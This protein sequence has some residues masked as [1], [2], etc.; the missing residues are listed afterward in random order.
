MK[1]Y[2]SAFLCFISI[3]LITKAWQ[4]NDPFFFYQEKHGHAGFAYV[5]QWYLVNDAPKH[6]YD[7]TNGK[8]DINVKPLWNQNITGKGIVIGIVDDFIQGD[9][10]DLAPNYREDLSK[11]FYENLKISDI[12]KSSTIHYDYPYNRY[13]YA[14]RYAHGTAVA[15]IAAASGGNGI[16]ITGVAPHAGLAGL[17]SG[18]S[19]K[20]IDATWHLAGIDKTT[21]KY[22][23]EPSIHIKN[24]SYKNR[25][26]LSKAIGLTSK[27]NVIHV[28]AAGNKR[29]DNF[30]SLEKQGPSHSIMVSAMN[31]AGNYTGYSNYGANVFVTAPGGEGGGFTISSK[32]TNQ[33]LGIFRMPTTDLSWVSAGYNKGKPEIVRRL[34]PLELSRHD[35]S[36]PD[37]TAYFAGTSGVAPIVSGTLALAKEINPL[38]DHR[39][40]KHCLVK[41]S[42]IVDRDDKSYMG[43][44]M[45]NAAGIYFNNNYG[46]GLIDATALGD[47]VQETAYVTAD[48]ESIAFNMRNIRS[49]TALSQTFQFA[50][51]I[52]F[53][54]EQLSFGVD[55]F[56]QDQKSFDDL[57]IDIISPQG[58]RS[59][60][61]TPPPYC[62]LK[63]KVDIFYD[64]LPKSNKCFALYKSQPFT[65]NTF[66]GENAH[67][68]WT[69]SLQDATTGLE[70][71]SLEDFQATLFIGKRIPQLKEFQSLEES[72]D[73][74]ALTLL[75][76]N[77]NWFV[78]EKGKT[79]R[80]KD[81]ILI[82]KV[83][84][85]LMARLKKLTSKAIAST[86]KVVS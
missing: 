43:G 25:N 72:A 79:L 45:K 65:T 28:V 70:S 10:P 40:A 1:N 67:G 83:P 24:H 76:H 32:V 11:I 49:S 51:S 21:G 78:I 33:L 53:P 52:D 39:M 46:F 60:I 22:V 5:G 26:D 15:G 16:G 36:S 7:D 63:S 61:L 44:W 68:E 47:V 31:A 18:F 13:D 34:G 71:F 20:T 27:N 57:Q 3:P 12:K 48:R 69:L 74:N 42:R 30:G 41:S 14:Y 75:K 9:H 8:F 80:L 64:S 86:S 55:L 59:K 81:G 77:N 35:L 29:S 66:W 2:L 82:E 85:L 38:L 56:F 50:D 37:Y 58:T 4:P 6:V 19:E 62:L 73:A 17:S 84:S 23:S 54:V